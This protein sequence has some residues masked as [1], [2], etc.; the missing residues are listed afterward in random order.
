MPEGFIVYDSNIFNNG[1]FNYQKPDINFIP[2]PLDK[3]TEKV[4]APKIVR[5]NV[6]VGVSVA[7]LNYD[8]GIL[9]K[10]ITEN[11]QRK[12][13][14]VIN[15]NV[16]AARAGYD[17]I[18]EKFQYIPEIEVEKIDRNSKLLLSGNDGI[19]L[20]AVKAGCKF[21]AAYPMTPTSPIL[22]LFAAAEKNFSIVTKH[23]ESEIAVMNIA[24]GASFAGVRAM[25]ATAGGGF[26]LMNEGLSGAAMTETPI[27]VVLGQRPAPATGLTTWTEQGDMLFA[28][29]ASHGEFPRVVMAHG[30]PEESFYLTKEAFNLAEKYQITVI[31]ILDKFL[32]EHNFTSEELFQDK[33]K[34]N[35][36]KLILENGDIED[37][38]NY[39]RY[40][41][42]KDGVSPRV[43]F[44]L[45][46]GVH[47]A[48]TD[49]HDE[50]GFSEGSGENRTKMMDKRFRKLKNLVNEMKG[51]I[52]YGSENAEN[53]II[54]LAITKF[55][56]R[57][58]M[59]PYGWFGYN[60]LK[61]I[62]S[63]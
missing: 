58:N 36:G 60:V 47:I 11:F 59:Q 20:G 57:E 52:L 14:R 5:N 30:D 17:F 34:V 4:G 54:S 31:I 43:I 35:R 16:D 15:F 37:R 3:L 40:K 29:H 23:A 27:V 41:D 62:C 26:A 50:Y 33:I 6:A 45:K 28:V 9:K 51:P 21:Y 49:E 44:R 2:V 12:G 10:I 22:H 24:V 55:F 18:K 61:R 63:T 8:F 19:F 42:T 48:N 13:V 46:D 38:E 1:D 39:L 25:V 7:L 32:A 53:T 56:Y